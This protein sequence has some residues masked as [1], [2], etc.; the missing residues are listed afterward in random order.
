[1]GTFSTDVTSL[2]FHTRLLPHWEIF[3]FVL[4]LN[5]PPTGA[6]ALFEANKQKEANQQDLYQPNPSHSYSFS[7]FPSQKVESNLYT[8]RAQKQNLTTESY[9]TLILEIRQFSCILKTS[10]YSKTGSDS[11][12]IPCCDL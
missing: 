9:H 2:H 11:L 3:N 12:I 10:L 1:M 6:T 7:F 5:Q 4:D 8:E